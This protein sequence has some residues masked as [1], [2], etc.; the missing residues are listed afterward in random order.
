MEKINHTEQFSDI[1]KR[2]KFNR[3]VKKPKFPDITN[4]IIFTPNP[5]NYRKITTLKPF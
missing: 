1:F 3:T 5:I 4:F 2:K